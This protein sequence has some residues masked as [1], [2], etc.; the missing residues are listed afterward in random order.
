M[1]HD[2]VRRVRWKYVLPVLY[3]ALALYAWFDFTR[4][5]QEGYAALGLML[6]TLPVSAAGLI[7]TSAL[8]K[9]GFVLLPSGLGHYTAHAVYFWPSALLITALLYGIC[10]SLSRR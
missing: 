2:G 6:V 10:S 1:R 3:L 8:G 7:L 9:T 4:T 5:S